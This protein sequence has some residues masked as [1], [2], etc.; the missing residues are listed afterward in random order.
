MGRAVILTPQAQ[1]DFQGIVKFIRRDNPQKARDFGYMLIDEALSLGSFPSMGRI[2][3]EIDEECVR[4]ITYGSYRIIYEVPPDSTALY[5]LR[6]W[7]AAR[8]VPE[9]PPT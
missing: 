4:E 8:G 3:P 7:H 1:E 2:V 5:V 9:I 6:F